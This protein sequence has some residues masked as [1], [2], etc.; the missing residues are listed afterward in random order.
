[1]AETWLIYQTDS[2]GQ[3]FTGS[4]FITLNDFWCLV[5]WQVMNKCRN[6]VDDLKDVLYKCHTLNNI[7]SSQNEW[8][9]FFLYAVLF[10]LISELHF[11]ALQ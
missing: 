3:I 9:F 7:R 1:M 10:V 2:F 5:E 8:A 4:P 6:F 11:N